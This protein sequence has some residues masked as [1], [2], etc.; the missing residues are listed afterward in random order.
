MT[1]KVS[2]FGL[3]LII[4]GFSCFEDG[5]QTLSK[6]FTSTVSQMNY[7]A[8]NTF[9][10]VLVCILVAKWA[11]CSSESIL[12]EDLVPYFLGDGFCDDNLNIL[13]C[14]Y[15]LGDCCS[16]GKD[17]C[18]QCECLE[19][20][21][22]TTKSNDLLVISYFNGTHNIT[23]EYFL[24][25]LLG[26]ATTT[27]ELTLNASSTISTSSTSFQNSEMKKTTTTFQFIK[28]H[29]KYPQKSSATKLQFVKETIVFIVL[30]MIQTTLR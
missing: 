6:K 21:D 2:I 10:F 3:Y 29:A 7:R 14:E 20:L 12:Q 17:F 22:T 28:L 27:K 15:D 30:L 16:G 25:D 19:E 24:E 4:S 1:K 8:I 18:V 11:N 13:A 26:L 9:I 5:F 23:E